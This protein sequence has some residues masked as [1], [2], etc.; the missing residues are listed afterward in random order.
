MERARACGGASDLRAGSPARAE[1]SLVAAEA[2]LDE[3]ALLVPLDTG[4]GTFLRDRGE[5]MRL[6]M[7]ARLARGDAAGALR[8]RTSRAGSDPPPGESSTPAKP[9]CAEQ[10]A[11]N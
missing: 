7:D 3:L 4:R 11:D 8:G 5:S 10:R 9:A 6:L 1:T 2:L